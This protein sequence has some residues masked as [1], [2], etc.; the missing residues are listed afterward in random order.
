M[1]TSMSQWLEQQALVRGGRGLVRTPLVRT[2]LVRTPLVRTPQSHQIDLS[3][4]DYLG[5]AQDPRLAEA[6]ASA[7]KIWGTGA[8]STRR[9]AGTTELPL[10]REDN[11]A[12]LCG[13]ESALVFSS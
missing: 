13:M 11:L 10:K 7:A 1:S 5:L 9:V 3:S 4:N 8:T 12:R 6:A 2:P